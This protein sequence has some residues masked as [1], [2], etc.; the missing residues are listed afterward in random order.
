MGTKK[1]KTD[2][3]FEHQVWLQRGLCYYCDKEMS[4]D[5]GIV[6]PLPPSHV[7][8]DHYIA[9]SRGG[10]RIVA[11][12]HRCNN[13][14]GDWGAE[15]FRKVV[16][17]LLQNEAI[18]AAWHEQVPGLDA[19]LRRAVF[20]ERMKDKQREKPSIH[21]QRRIKREIIIFL[22]QVKKLGSR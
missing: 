19:T 17:E 18:E 14:K 6:S 2:L 4:Q 7:T 13:I 10:K 16:R 12:C 21:R 5:E 15:R 8:R 22:R 11:S 20:I 1:M 3:D 9:N